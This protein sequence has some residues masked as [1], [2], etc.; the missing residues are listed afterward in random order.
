MAPSFTGND[1]AYLGAGYTVKTGKGAPFSRRVGSADGEN[2]VFGQLSSSVCGSFKD[3]FSSFGEHIIRVIQ[4]VTEE[5]VI[6]AHALPI[7]AF[8]EHAQIIGDRTVY[9]F[10]H[11][12]VRIDDFPGFSGV[13]SD[14]AVTGAATTRCPLPAALAESDFRPETDFYRDSHRFLLQDAGGQGWR[15]RP[16][17]LATPFSSRRP[18]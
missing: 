17:A 15:V 12:A 8:V 18:C 16:N 14:T 1:T 11:P 3:R 2:V 13:D 7:V 6:G 5:E 4:S 10:P 9:E